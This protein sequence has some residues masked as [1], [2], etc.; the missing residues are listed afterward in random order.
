MGRRGPVP[1]TREER[2]AD[3]NA[4]RRP[5]PAPEPPLPP[6]LPEPPGHLSREA[7][8][9]WARI[10][11]MLAEQRRVCPLDMAVLALYCETWADVVRGRLEMVKLQEPD[12]RGLVVET[13]KGQVYDHPVVK[14]VYAAQ[15]QCAQHLS[16]LGLSPISR[17]RMPLPKDAPS[18]AIGD[19]FQSF[20]AQRDDPL[21]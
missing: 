11:P 2:L 6:G 13:D 18:A 17:L 16:Q 8:E 7:C 10:L 15:R 20:A 9:E 5:L 14:R 3:G 1:K 4:S 21:S 19:P 12:G